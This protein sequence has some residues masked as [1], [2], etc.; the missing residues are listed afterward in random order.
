VNDLKA[1]DAAILRAGGRI[2]AAYRDDRN[3]LHT[4]SAVCT[5]LR[6]IVHWNDTERTWDCP[7]HGSRFDI[8]G[9]VMAA[10]ATKP[11]EV[12]DLTAPPH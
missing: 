6:C 10:P 4:V 5:H 12:V 8:E 3:K 1:G 2:V 11:L 9:N 7:C